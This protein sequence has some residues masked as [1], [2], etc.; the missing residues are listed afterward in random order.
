MSNEPLQIDKIDFMVSSLIDRA[1]HWTMIRELTKNAIEAAEKAGED[2]FIHWTTG[3][4]EGTRKAVLWN[5]G[6]GLDAS[7]LKTATDLA[8]EINKK[9]SID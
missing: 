5:T 1:P 8:C 2:K 7:Q 9:L 6:P 3:E 4:Y